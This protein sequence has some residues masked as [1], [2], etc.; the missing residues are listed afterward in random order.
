MSPTLANKG[1][2][3]FDNR[4]KNIPKILSS[5]AKNNT[6]IETLVMILKE[7]QKRNK[8]YTDNIYFLDGR[9]GSGKST[10]MITS[11]YK[12]ITNPN[13]SSVMC[14]EPRVALVK[15]NATD[16]CRYDDNLRI[17]TN[18][19]MLTGNDKIIPSKSGMLYC[20]SAMLTMTIKKCLEE[21]SPAEL[22]RKYQFIV[23]DEVHT[24]GVPEIDLLLVIKEF[25][26]VF[27]RSITKPFTFI[28]TSAT[29]DIESL[30]NYYFPFE[31]ASEI[32]DDYLMIGHVL[33]SANFPV[34]ERFIDNNSTNIIQFYK[35]LIDEAWK[36]ESTIVQNKK[37]IPCRDILIFC[38]G[39]MAID[40]IVNTIQKGINNE[41]PIFVTV[42]GT[43]MGQLTEWRRKNDS[44][45]R[46]HIIKFASTILSC[47]NTLLASAV[48]PN[49]EVNYNEMKIVV[50]T[51]VIE[52]GKTIATLYACIDN[53]LQLKP[54]S[55]PLNALSIANT[56]HMKKTNTNITTNLE[57]HTAV[58]SD[59]T[60]AFREINMNI[61][62]IDKFTI[63]QRM[64]RVGREAAGIFVHYY[65]EDVYNMLPEMPL[66]EFKNMMQVSNYV[67]MLCEP[68]KC[69]DIINKNMFVQIYSVDT[70][71]YTYYDML[72]G[73]I[74]T[75]NGTYFNL[76]F[77][78]DNYLTHNWLLVAQYMYLILGYSLLD[79]LM[80]ASI[81]RKSIADK[82]NI[83]NKCILSLK[84]DKH[85]ILKMQTI[86][87]TISNF[88][89]DAYAIYK[90]IRFDNN[91]VHYGL[92]FIAAKKAK[93]N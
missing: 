78:N 43:T 70:A 67:S 55:Y 58:D 30:V 23:I 93:N 89:I 63:T 1:T 25:L 46:I 68:N 27:S 66:Y 9:T 18:V 8:K 65:S 39:P 31:E 6:A 64:G 10:L 57:A 2:F 47:A 42:N 79:A 81:N 33:G 20:T 29:I 41:Y 91:Y 17:G 86:D 5:A 19:G 34:D 84:Y 45:K 44:K 52:S 83:D 37:R 59:N 51:P 11:L 40:Y 49:F 16:I 61:L 74:I 62:P 60:S 77:I 90:S 12:L 87:E 13:N 28:F 26:S 7:K 48:E 22:I 75:L 3:T 92:P 72:L 36:S 35:K 80:L 69:T 15:S 50:S 88:I 85:D 73:N 21:G 53:G 38:H 24:L 32:Y 14:V 4:A 82:L 54:I 71:M 76:N 56:M